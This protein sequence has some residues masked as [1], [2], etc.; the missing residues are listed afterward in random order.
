MQTHFCEERLCAKYMGMRVSCKRVD[1]LCPSPSL[2]IQ[3]SALQKYLELQAQDSNASVSVGAHYHGQIVK[4]LARNNCGQDHATA[5]FGS[6]SAKNVS[7]GWPVFGFPWCKG[8]LF[9]DN[10]FPCLSSITILAIWQRSY[11]WCLYYPV[12]IVHAMSPH[13]WDC[14]F[15]NTNTDFRWPVH[16]RPWSNLYS[17][18]SF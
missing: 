7:F 18:G 16:A 17:Y 9:P 2:T 4:A 5:Q 12:L 15:I 11:V 14:G 8:S 1:V 13:C 3:N 6:N 10:T